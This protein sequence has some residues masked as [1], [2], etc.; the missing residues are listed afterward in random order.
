MKL[1]KDCVHY[2]WFAIK[3]KHPNN[4]KIDVID[5]CISSILDIYTL[6]AHNCNELCGKNAKW[7]ESKRKG[8]R[9]KYKGWYNNE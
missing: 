1:C 3:C 9:E 4:I 7:F 5:G 2:R 8:I 6:R